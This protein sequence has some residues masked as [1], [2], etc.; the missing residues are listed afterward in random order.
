MSERI[1]VVAGDLNVFKALAA[2]AI[3]E[4]CIVVKDAPIPVDMPTMEQEP[5]NRKERRA[6][7]KG[8]R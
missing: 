6:A 7:K 4:D 8:K 5:R 1:L 2:D 3:G